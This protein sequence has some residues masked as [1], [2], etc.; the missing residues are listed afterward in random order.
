[1]QY[2]KMFEPVSIGSLELKNRI[3]M[4]PLGTALADEN[5]NPTPRQVLHYVERAKN[6]VGL[7]IVEHTS[8][9][10]VGSRSE[11]ASGIW[12]WDSL[13]HWKMLVDAVH[14]HGTS[15]G[16]QIGHQGQCTD[17]SRKLGTEAQAPSAVRCRLIQEK[18]RAVTKEEMLQFRKDYVRAV[19][20]AVAAGF[21]TVVL[22]F[23]NGYFLAEWLSGRTNK[24]TDEYG[25]NLENRLRF[26]LELVRDV[27]EAVGPDFPLIVRLAS[28]EINGGREIEETR[29]VAQA[30]EEAGINALDINSGSWS[31]YDWEFPSF[32][33]PEGFLLSDAEFIKKAVGIPVISG[34]RIIEPRMAE[35]ALRDGRVDLVSVT[36]GLLADPQWVSKT[37]AGEVDSIRRCIG[38][39]RCINDR[40]QGGLVCSVNPFERHEE[41]WAIRPAPVKKKILVVGGGPG[42]LQAAVV[43]AQ[44]G[45]QV[46]LVEKNSDLGGMVR[47]AGV[48]PH[49]WVI[50]GLV[51]ALAYDAR[52]SGVEILLD[53]EVDAQ[54]IAQ[55]GF[56]EVILST[57]SL[58]VIPKVLTANGARVISAVDVLLGKEW[59]GDRVA[60]I[61]GG[62]IG[63]ECADFLA[64]Y[65]KQVT[66]YEMLDKIAADMYWNIRKTLLSCLQKC[67]VIWRTSSRVTSIEDGVVRYERAGKEFSDGPFDDIICAVGMRPDNAL[68]QQL[69]QMG[70][71]P[72]VV[73]DAAGVGRLYE[74]LTSAVKAT[75][76]L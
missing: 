11:R 76:E 29:L 39:T 48:P 9:Q 15:I 75:I 31:E 44:R 25:G 36:R 22:H 17:Y 73:G 71:H 66:I 67:D 8:M 12:S 6:G 56:E 14:A 16:I 63:C 27:R 18:T 64:Q 26:P 37:A 41:D 2:T 40:E 69:E 72:I 59:V 74:V 47:A 23:T 30:L 62:A 3:V 21:D 68:A 34:G 32:F 35:Q 7:I 65:N 42:G 60:I 1:M 28:R 53:R 46:T 13:P 5:H 10:L 61:G 57:G 54:W 45:H 20:I 52:K 4:G 51:T 50:L 49:K 19:Q 70:L 43:A 33:Q 58:P 38:C 24:R 55:G